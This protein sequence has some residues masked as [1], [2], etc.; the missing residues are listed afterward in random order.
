MGTPTAVEYINLSRIKFSDVGLTA[1]HP[2]NGKIVLSGEKMAYDS[3]N[4]ALFIYITSDQLGKPINTVIYP[5]IEFGT[6]AT[7]YEPYKPAQTLIIPTLG[8]L[9]GIPVSSGGNY[10]DEKGQQWVADEIDLARGER[11]QWIGNKVLQESDLQKDAPGSIYVKLRNIKTASNANPICSHLKYVYYQTAD[12][13]P[14]LCIS[15]VLDDIRLYLNST[16]F[17]VYKDFVNNNEVFIIWALKTPARTPLPPE[18]IAAYKAL[19]TYSPNTS[20]VNDEGSWM[21]VGY[22]GKPVGMRNR[23]VK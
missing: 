15:K 20:I 14:I 1:T 9:P 21:K 3:S 17:Q 22:R 16:D 2:T 19:H 7:E 4:H 11:V 12:K 13:E 18:T 6:V 23:M 10:T 8:G 5:Q